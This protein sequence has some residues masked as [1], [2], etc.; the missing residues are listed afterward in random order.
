[1]VQQS[2]VI[3]FFAVEVDEAELQIPVRLGVF[4]VGVQELFVT[5]ERDFVIPDDD[6]IELV[7]Y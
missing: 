6:A 5:A 4:A 7:Y 2:G 3:E 1:V